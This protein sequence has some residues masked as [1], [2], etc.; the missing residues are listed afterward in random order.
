MPDQQLETSQTEA[1]SGRKGNSGSAPNRPNVGVGELLTRDR[2]ETPRF[3]FGSKVNIEETETTLHHRNV[4]ING[5]EP[6]RIEETQRRNVGCKEGERRRLKR[7]KQGELT[8]SRKVGMEQR[9]PGMCGRCKKKSRRKGRQT[10]ATPGGLTSEEGA[11]GKWMDQTPRA[12]RRWI[13]SQRHRN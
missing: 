8:F 7:R 6:P 11:K 2:E 4:D 5:A 10:K 3:A 9:K 12:W 1:E 13:T